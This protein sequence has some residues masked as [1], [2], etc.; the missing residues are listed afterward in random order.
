VEQ[1][2]A[3]QLF[4]RVVTTN[5]HPR[6]MAAAGGLLEVVSVAPLLMAKVL[7]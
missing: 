4:E 5:S 6:A 7:E 2:L 3:C 1:L